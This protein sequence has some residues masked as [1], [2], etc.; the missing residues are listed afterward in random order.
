MASERGCE[1]ST[2]S[3]TAAGHVAAQGNGAAEERAKDTS[4]VAGSQ[5]ARSTRSPRTDKPDQDT[6]RSHGP[7]ASRGRTSPKKVNGRSPGARKRC[8]YGL[9]RFTDAQKGVFPRA[10]REIQAGRKT[11]CW[12]WF[13]IPTPPYIVNGVEKGSS[14][15]RKYA[16]RSDAEGLAYLGFTHDG[17]SLRN[18]Y[19]EIMCAILDQLRSGRSM[20]SLVGHFDGPK[21]I[22][23]ALFFERLTRSTDQELHDVLAEV[24][25]LVGAQ[26]AYAAL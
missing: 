4:H 16:L 24:L 10:L 12:M 2:N 9:R 15:N 8:E 17:V 23:S 13:I 11:T 18:N 5:R 1:G 22:S 7:M 20:A 14:Q 6:S 26:G 25:D 3:A 21:L 19:F